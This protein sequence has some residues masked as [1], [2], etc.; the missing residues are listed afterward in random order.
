MWAWSTYVF[1]LIRPGAAQ[2]Q[3]ENTAPVGNNDSSIPL[4]SLSCLRQKS[5]GSF[6]DPKKNSAV[7]FVFVS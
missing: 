3:K 4:C 2:I 5:W 1:I 6:A 7:G